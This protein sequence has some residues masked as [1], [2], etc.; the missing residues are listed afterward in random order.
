MTRTWYTLLE[1]IQIQWGPGVINQNN[2]FLEEKACWTAV[3][4]NGGET[5]NI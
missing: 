5:Q 4:D 1:V 3:F 2:V